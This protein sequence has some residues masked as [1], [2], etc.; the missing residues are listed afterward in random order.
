M[1]VTWIKT[2]ALRPANHSAILYFSYIWKKAQFKRIRKWAKTSPVFPFN[3][4]YPLLV[5]TIF[6]KRPY[7]NIFF[8][9]SSCVPSERVQL[10]YFLLLHISILQFGICSICD[11]FPVCA[12]MISFPFFVFVRCSFSFQFSIVLAYLCGKSSNS[13]FS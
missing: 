3:R 7:N 2:V 10:T 12:Q 6:A 5:C 13:P 11:Q 1:K 8:S 4:N 9:T